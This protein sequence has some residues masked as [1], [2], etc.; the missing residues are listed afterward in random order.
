[1]KKQHTWEK[2]EDAD[3]EEERTEIMGEK[4][5]GQKRKWSLFYLVCIMCSLLHSWVDS[6]PSSSEPENS[7]QNNTAK[8]FSE[9]QTQAVAR[10]M[11]TGFN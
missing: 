7:R 9:L 8:W 10:K 2:M 1:M 3:I 11:W 5:R 6:R 4:A